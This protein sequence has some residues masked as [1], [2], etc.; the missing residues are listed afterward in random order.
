[1]K[2]QRLKLWCFSALIFTIFCC[3]YTD[4]G[5]PLSDQEIDEYVNERLTGGS[6][7]EI[8]RRLEAF[9]RNDSGKQ[10]L[11]FN[12]FD[13]NENPGLVKGAEPGE[14]AEQLMARYMEHMIP[15]L[16]SRA[17]HPVITGTATNLAMDVIGI[18]NA[19][20]W[21]AGAVFRYRSKRTFMEIVRNP[22][23]GGEHHFKKAA[24]TKTIAYPVEPG[25]YPSDL[26][27][28]LAL[29]LIALTALI[30]AQRL[31]RLNR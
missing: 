2:F 27:I 15:A 12:S 18:D 4:F 22:D 28:L 26:R 6:D 8:I 30:D 31:S 25:L 9:F 5:G 14:N 17:S 7:P 16:L 11:M 13:Y 20:E 19:Q 3:W 23:F 21:D 10:F 1:M 24:L 29:I